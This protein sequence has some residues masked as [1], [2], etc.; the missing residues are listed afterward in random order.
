MFGFAIETLTPQTHLVDELQLDSLDALD[1]VVRLQDRLGAR[2]P[3]ERL[4]ELRTIGDVVAVTVEIS[5]DTADA[6]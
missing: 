3:E 1:L 6:R 4:M 2:I 5:R